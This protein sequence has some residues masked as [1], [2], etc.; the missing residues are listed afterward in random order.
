MNDNQVKEAM[1]FM[2]RDM[3]KSYYNADDL[4]KIIRAFDLCNNAKISRD[5]KSY[6]SENFV[7]IAEE[8]KKIIEN[9]ANGRVKV[10]GTAVPMME[11]FVEVFGKD[12]V[13]KAQGMTYQ[14]SAAAFRS[15]LMLKRMVFKDMQIN[16]P[17]FNVEVS[18]PVKKQTVLQ[19]RKP[20]Q[21][22]SFLQQFKAGVK[23]SL[24][25]TGQHI[26]KNVRRYALIAAAFLGVSG[27]NVA[28]SEAQRG[29]VD[30]K[31]KSEI[32][33]APKIAE[34][35][36]HREAVRM[37]MLSVAP[38]KVM[39]PAITM[40]AKLP[41]LNI[42]N[43]NIP[44]LKSTYAQPVEEYSDLALKNQ[45][46]YI[47]F[48]DDL[49]GKFHDNISTLKNTNI[50]K[51]A[52]YNEQESLIAKYGKPRHISR[53]KSCES[54]SYTTFLSVIDKNENQDNYIAEACKKLL[55]QVPNPHACASNTKT[56]KAS[57]CKNLRGSLKEK[58]QDNKFGI[59]MM[60]THN[61]KGG[62]HRWTV[63]GTGDGNAYLLAYNNNRITRMNVDNMDKI[64]GGSGFYSD[65]GSKIYNQ[66]N[67]I[68]AEKQRQQPKSNTYLAFAAN[69][70]QKVM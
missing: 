54:L 3:V 70:S 9:F 43:E 44:S 19:Y 40:P 25:S 15:K 63:I 47:T 26:S 35:K 33:Q 67:V 23:N 18:A 59:Y 6:G 30:I 2:H 53:G 32:V 51:S 69:F 16:K 62:L 45:T 68:G 61:N 29:C 1:R 42:V 12:Y 58:L 46:D 34:I 56:F 21:K 49:L 37:E 36:E 4:A 24:N 10:A 38:A 60:W 17:V 5:Y 39:V 52:F 7:M 27:A 13:Q 55:L 41:K 64:P 66:A 31:E 28:S 50:N 57:S 11:N 8:A 20:E 22:R 48:V 65:L 14:Y